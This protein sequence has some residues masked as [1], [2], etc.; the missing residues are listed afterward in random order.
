V[1]NRHTLCSAVTSCVDNRMYLSLLLL[2]LHLHLHL[3]L[4]CM[5]Q[6]P[7][8]AGPVDPAAGLT[9]WPHVL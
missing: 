9:P 2:L 8:L 1:S 6:V 5:G 4:C 3:L 7:S